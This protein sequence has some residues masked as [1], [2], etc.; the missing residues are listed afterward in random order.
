MIKHS[1]FIDD[2]LV[3]ASPMLE[4]MRRDGL[5]RA[6]V[7]FA[8]RQFLA[9]RGAPAPNLDAETLVNVLKVSLKSL[10]TPASLCAQ[11]YAAGCRTLCC[12][13]KRF[14]ARLPAEAL[15][16]TVFM[17]AGVIC[18]RSCCLK[19]DHRGLSLF[20]RPYM[21]RNTFPVLVWKRRTI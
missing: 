4:R 1:L 5:D 7:P 20:M 21:F 15:L 6:W 18:T 11:H 13:R 19:P 9:W 14:R 12:R 8:E 17:C 10:P 3:E 2:D 16:F